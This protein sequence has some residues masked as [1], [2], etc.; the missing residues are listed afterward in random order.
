MKFTKITTVTYD[1]EHDIFF[2]MKEI[3]DSHLERN[4]LNWMWSNT[5]I[6]LTYVPS[7]NTPQRIQTNQWNLNICANNSL[8]GTFVLLDDA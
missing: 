1:D 6:E 5:H 4:E 8:T 3:T 2:Y 7:N